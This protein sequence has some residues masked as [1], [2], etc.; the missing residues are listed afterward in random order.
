MTFAFAHR[1]VISTNV[2]HS[3]PEASSC[4]GGSTEISPIPRPRADEIV[5]TEGL[6]L[7]AEGLFLPCRA[8]E[9]EQELFHSVP[10][11]NGGCTRRFIDENCADCSVDGEC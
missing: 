10:V 3:R 9:P 5:R 11:H 8:V 6:F 1:S 4:H 2:Q 7:T